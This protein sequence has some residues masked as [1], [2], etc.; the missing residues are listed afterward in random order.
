MAGA[1]AAAAAARR[2]AIS[3]VSPGLGRPLPLQLACKDHFY[4]RDGVRDGPLHKFR[5]N[6]RHSWGFEPSS[7]EEEE[8][9]FEPSSNP[10]SPAEGAQVHQKN[11]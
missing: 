1:K 8:D 11:R 2:P 3:T 6:V 10:W 5:D 9:E 7:S 4:R